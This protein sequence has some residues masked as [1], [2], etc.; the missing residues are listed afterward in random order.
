M[1]IRDPMF[2]SR[3]AQHQSACVSL[4]TVSSAGEETVGI[5][6]PLIGTGQLLL[7]TTHVI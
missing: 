3:S 2:R 5:I 6:R 7:T 1:R 4:N